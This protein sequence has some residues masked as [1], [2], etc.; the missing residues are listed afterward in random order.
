M[1]VPIKHLKQSS[2]HCSLN[3][4]S[5]QWNSGKEKLTISLSSSAPEQT[6]KPMDTESSPKTVLANSLG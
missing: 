3:F 2:L 6:A 4:D 1:F 5:A